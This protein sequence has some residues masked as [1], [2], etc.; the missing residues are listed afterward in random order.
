ALRDLDGDGRL[1]LLVGHS[2]NHGITRNSVSVFRGDGDGKFDGSG[3]FDVTRDAPAAERPWS[4]IADD[5]DG[6]GRPD[7]VVGGVLD[8]AY[9]MP[10]NGD[11]SLGTP[12]DVGPTTA[13]TTLVADLDGDGTSDLITP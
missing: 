4:L 10:G 6:D 7:V 12:S 11:G 2:F 9:V 3:T 13:G 1:D 8:R 5:L